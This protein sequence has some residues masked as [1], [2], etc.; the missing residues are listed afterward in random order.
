MAS[1]KFDEEI[2]ASLH[3][4]LNVCRNYIRQVSQG[5]VKGNVS[6]YPI[7]VVM[8]SETDIDLGLPI[9]N[10]E[11]MD[12]TWAVNASHLEDF[13]NNKIII[14]SKVADF[15]KNYKD[16]NEFMCV[17]VAEEGM[18]SFI[19]MPYDKPQNKLDVS[20]DQLN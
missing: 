10:K 4:D 17:F 19:F 13:V 8:R 3:N 14:E 16:P 9:I 6:K 11:E 2:L 15:R 20:K 18:M 12:L 5:M 1:L 7:F